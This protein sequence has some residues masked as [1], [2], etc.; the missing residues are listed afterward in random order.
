MKVVNGFIARHT[1]PL[2]GIGAFLAVAVV[3]T[4]SY[5]A[6]TGPTTI[7]GW[8]STI[9][10]FFTTNMPA[11][12][13]ALIGLAGATVILAVG[14]N[15]LGRVWTALASLGGSSGLGGRRRR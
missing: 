4:P 9:V 3:A 14:R 6:S 5:A 12:A 15:L 13:L 10:S 7:A 1:R 11:V 2:A 8:T